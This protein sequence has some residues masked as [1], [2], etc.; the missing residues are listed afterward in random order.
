[1][2]FQ[3]CCWSPLVDHNFSLS[4]MPGIFFS[5]RSDFR[6]VFGEWGYFLVDILWTPERSVGLFKTRVQTIRYGFVNTQANSLAQVIWDLIV[7]NGTHLIFFSN[8]IRAEFP[9]SDSPMATCISELPGTDHLDDSSVP[10]P[11]RHRAEDRSIWLV[12]R[13]LWASPIC[14]L[15]VSGCKLP[16]TRLCWIFHDDS[17][18]SCK[19]ISVY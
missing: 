4:S 19:L 16:T 7:S 5:L 3:I 10:N 8:K 14:C 17:W 9:C 13:N 2:L 6:L 15:S 12:I 18:T 11:I 1:M